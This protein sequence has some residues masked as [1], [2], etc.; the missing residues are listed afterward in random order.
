[1]LASMAAD[2]RVANVPP[3]HALWYW[4]YAATITVDRHPLR[5]WCPPNDGLYPIRDQVGKQVSAVVL[6]YTCRLL[7]ADSLEFIAISKAKWS[8]AEKTVLNLLVVERQGAFRCRVMSLGRGRI[9][10]ESPRSGN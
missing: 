10:R 4:T 9:E 7:Q 3:S 8:A 1:M 5:D 2:L 6:G